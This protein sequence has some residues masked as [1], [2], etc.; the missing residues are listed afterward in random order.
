MRYCSLLDSVITLETVTIAMS[1]KPTESD[2]EDSS[3][4]PV[5]NNQTT[6]NIPMNQ[7]PPM[8]MFVPPPGYMIPPGY[9]YFQPPVAPW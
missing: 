9:P 2:N 5:A 4:R 6:S 1:Q 8:N 3:K 7:Y